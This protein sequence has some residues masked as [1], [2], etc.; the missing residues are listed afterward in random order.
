M[1]NPTTRLNC[2][3]MVNPTTWL[4]FNCITQH[5]YAFESM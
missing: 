3:L 2:K 5:A 4:N 1:V